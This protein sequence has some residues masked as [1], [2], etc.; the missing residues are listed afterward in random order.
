MHSFAIGRSIPNCLGTKLERR[1]FMIAKAC[2]PNIAIFT[3]KGSWISNGRQVDCSRLTSL[4]YLLTKGER[5]PT[6]LLSG[7]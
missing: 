5:P 6:T 4:R 1:L 7:L 2:G 3:F